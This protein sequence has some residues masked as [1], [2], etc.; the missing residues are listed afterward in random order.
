MNKAIAIVLAVTAFGSAAHADRLIGGY[1]T[2][3]GTYVAPYFRSNADRYQSNNYS[4]KGNYN[5]YTGNI[6]TQPYRQRNT[7]YGGTGR[8]VACPAYSWC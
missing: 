1:V 7:S 4:Y 3:R 8:G 5:P 2:K 6:G